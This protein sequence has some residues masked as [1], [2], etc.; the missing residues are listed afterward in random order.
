MK[1]FAGLD[2]T[3][4][5]PA[6]EPPDKELE[7]AWTW[8]FFSKAAEKC[9]KGGYPFG[10]PVSTCSDA[11]QFVGAMFNAHGVQLVNAKGGIT[12]NNDTTGER[13]RVVQKDGA[14]LPTERLCLG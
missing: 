13:A 10:T 1:Q 5:Y 9:Q 8:D 12:V 3:K 2:V 11:V 7:A 6:G 4:M 14:V